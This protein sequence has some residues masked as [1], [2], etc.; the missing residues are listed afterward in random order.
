LI[1]HYAEDL[2][3]LAQGGQYLMHCC[4][5]MESSFDAKVSAEY[6]FLSTEHFS[7]LMLQ[8]RYHQ[9]ANKNIENSKT[10]VAE[11]EKRENSH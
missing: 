2:R 3:R 8:E 10:Y 5:M 11:R 1:A 6:P 9:L 4:S 7:A